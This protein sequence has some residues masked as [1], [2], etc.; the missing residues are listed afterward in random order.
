MAIC[1]QM[2]LIKGQTGKSG[3]FCKLDLCHS[4]K[5]YYLEEKCLLKRTLG[6]PLTV[7][8][9]TGALHS[10]S[11][12]EHTFHQ[13]TTSVHHDTRL[14][15][16]VSHQCWLREADECHAL[17]QAPHSCSLEHFWKQLCKES[18]AELD[19]KKMFGSPKVLK[20]CE[21]YEPHCSNRWMYVMCSF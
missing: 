13:P 14:F 11:S 15:S 6:S 18:L 21:K 8:W 20:V 12:C 10:F 5:I 4:Q 3:R 7:L 1:K 19:L 2:G 9:G 17:I 16:V